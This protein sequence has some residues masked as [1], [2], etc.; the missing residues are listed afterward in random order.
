M[1]VNPSEQLFGELIGS[2]VSSF[3]ITFLF[4]VFFKVYK[5]IGPVENTDL[6][7][8]Q[9]SIVATVIN[10]IPFFEYFYF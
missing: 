5:T 1:K 10:G 6:I 9:A 7:A 2:I 8:L 3:V 4:F